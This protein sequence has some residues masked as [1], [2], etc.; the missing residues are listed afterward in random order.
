MKMNVHV[1]SWSG[2]RSEREWR[3]WRLVSII[4]SGVCERH[5]KLRLVFGESGIGWLPYLLERMD[6]TYRAR[7]A[8]ELELSCLPSE[9]FR[10]QIYAT[11]QK[12][13][14]GVKAMAEIAPDNVMWGSDYPHR[15]G[16]WP[17]SQAA[18]DEQF[19][20]VD[21]KVKRKMLSENVRAVYGLEL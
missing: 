19:L 4:L 5:P 17:D 16:T 7:L 15:D 1:G 11:F 3:R 2:A 12:D 13:L 10:R 8:N 20:D 14:H 6:D 9:Y 21:E 18:I